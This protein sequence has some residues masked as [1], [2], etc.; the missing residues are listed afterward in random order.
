MSHN[1]EFDKTIIMPRPG[2]RMPVINSGPA[3]RGDDSTVPPQLNA[4]SIAVNTSAELGIN[5]ILDAASVLLSL[6]GQLRKTA[7]VSYRRY[8]RCSLL[9]M[10]LS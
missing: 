9:L 2:G 5:P 1:D 3:A 4:A 6:I 10:H 7:V 8:Y